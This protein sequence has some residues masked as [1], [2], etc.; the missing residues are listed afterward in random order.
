MAGLDKRDILTK[1]ERSA[2]CGLKH[3]SKLRLC[4]TPLLF[5]QQLSGYNFTME[6][7]ALLPSFS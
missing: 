5:L 7:L 2:L 6:Q 3:P 1:R 4:Q